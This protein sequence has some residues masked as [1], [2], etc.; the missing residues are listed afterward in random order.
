MHKLHTRKDTSPKSQA[1]FPRNHQLHKVAKEQLPEWMQIYQAS[2]AAG[3][4]HEPRIPH[5][6]PS[7]GDHQDFQ[8]HQEPKTKGTDSP[9]QIQ[10]IQLAITTNENHTQKGPMTKTKQHHCRQAATY[11]QGDDPPH[12][13][14]CAPRDLAYTHFD[15]AFAQSEP[16][17]LGPF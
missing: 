6:K 11:A 4:G 8:S 5:L 15:H 13:F 14:E 2:T 16:Y 10:N 12:E 9:E 1:A 7:G 3:G 17:G